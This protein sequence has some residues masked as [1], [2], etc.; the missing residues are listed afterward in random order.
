MQMETSGKM[1][2]SRSEILESS[3]DIRPVRRLL[4]ADEAAGGGLRRPRSTSAF[5][6]TT[7]NRREDFLG[8]TKVFSLFSFTVVVDPGE[9]EKA[10]ELLRDAYYKGG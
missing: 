4:D 3:L 8:G 7:E 9:C 6:L 10:A 5:L 1:E 2:Q